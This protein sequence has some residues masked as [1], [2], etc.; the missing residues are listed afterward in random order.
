MECDETAAAFHIGLQPGALF[1]GRDGLDL[2]R[3]LIA[4]ASSELLALEI[5]PEQ[6]ASV[7]ALVA[8]AGYAHVEVLRD[9][10]GRERVVVGRERRS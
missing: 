7:A 6:A 8:G 10:A 4:Q 3:R 9:L 1:G 5:A 2:V